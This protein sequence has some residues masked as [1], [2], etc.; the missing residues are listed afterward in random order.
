M[1]S[2]KGFTAKVFSVVSSV[3]VGRS[4]RHRAFVNQGVFRRFGKVSYNDLQALNQCYTS[5]ND[6]K[7][8]VAEMPL[9]C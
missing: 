8:Y 3:V 9:S 7:L 1:A 6:V 5:R 2:L 4:V